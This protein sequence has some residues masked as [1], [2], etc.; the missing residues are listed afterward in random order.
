MASGNTVS[1]LLTSK[2]SESVAPPL[3]L[4]RHSPHSWH[5]VMVTFLTHTHTHTH[6]QAT[7][8][9]AVELDLPL[10]VLRRMIVHL[11]VTNLAVDF[12]SIFH[13]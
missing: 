9:G 11:P 12:I 4:W 8:A 3:I 7:Y 10:V 6:V 5:M 13:K 1:K 2:W